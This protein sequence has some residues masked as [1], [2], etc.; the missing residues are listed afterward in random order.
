MTSIL[1]LKNESLGRDS[2]P[3]IA[4]TPQPPLPAGE[5]EKNHSPLSRG[6]RGL[7]GES[8]LL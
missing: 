4:L 5:G 7:G 1:L 8:E 6:E 2:P 3:D